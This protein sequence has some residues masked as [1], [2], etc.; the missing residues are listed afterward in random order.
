MHQTHQRRCD[1]CECSVSVSP[2]WDSCFEIEP[3]EDK[4]SGPLAVSVGPR[5]HEWILN[6]KCTDIVEATGEMM[7]GKADAIQDMVDEAKSKSWMFLLCSYGNER[8]RVM[9]AKQIEIS[10][11]KI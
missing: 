11:I 1:A 8:P 7:D 3:M 2:Y 5:A 10:A 6:C 4:L 9:A